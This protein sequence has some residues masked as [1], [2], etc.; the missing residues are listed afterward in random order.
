VAGELGITLA[1]PLVTTVA[2][3]LHLIPKVLE[4]A[5]LEP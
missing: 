2:Q 3:I 5:G 4:V 1:G